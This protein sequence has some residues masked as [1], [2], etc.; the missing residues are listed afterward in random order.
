DHVLEVLRAQN[1]DSVAGLGDL[2]QAGADGAVA[3]AEMSPGQITLNALAFSGEVHESVGQL[4]AAHLGP[5]L[6]VTD[7][8]AVVGKHKQTVLEERVVERHVISCQATRAALVL[9]C[10]RAAAHDGRQRGPKPRRSYRGIEV[11]PLI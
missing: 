11:C 10:G 8:T 2:L 6:D 7:H 3:D 4:V 5:L 1:R 9:A